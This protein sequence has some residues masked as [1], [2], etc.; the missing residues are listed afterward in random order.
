MLTVVYIMQCKCIT[1]IIVILPG[2]FT[3]QTFLLLKFWFLAEPPATVP[4]SSE[5]KVGRQRTKVSIAWMDSRL[6]VKTSQA[7]AEHVVTHHFPFSTS[8]NAFELCKGNIL[9][10][11]NSSSVN[12]DRSTSMVDTSISEVEKDCPWHA[13]VLC[14]YGWMKFILKG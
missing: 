7:L 5:I 14:P 3:S 9:I 13:L 10:R 6:P 8:T 12:E 4:R 1:K 11:F 2:G